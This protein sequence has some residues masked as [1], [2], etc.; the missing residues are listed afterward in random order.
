MAGKGVRT[1]LIRRSYRSSLLRGPR[2]RTTAEKPV[3]QRKNARMPQPHVA[4]GMGLA[5]V[6]DRR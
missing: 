2:C 5:G 1:A 6:D 4:K 3:V